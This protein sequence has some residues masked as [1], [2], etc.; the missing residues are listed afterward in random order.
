MTEEFDTATATGRLMLT[1]LSGFAAHERDQIRERSMAGTD[2]LA[3]AGAWLGGIVPY[4][5]RKE[6]EDK[7]ARIVI[8]E[9]EI[10]GVGISEAEVMRQVYRMAAN[11]CVPCVRIADFLN[12]LPVPDA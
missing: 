5:Y 8:S 3:R 6:G 11:E 1:M 10:P 7:E 9:E 2:R 4:G 12:M